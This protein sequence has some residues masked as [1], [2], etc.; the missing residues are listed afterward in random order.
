MFAA[1][2]LCYF[3]CEELLR[4]VALHG[5]CVYN[6]INCGIMSTLLQDTEHLRKAVRLDDIEQ[7]EVAA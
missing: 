4:V 3:N 6:V 7:C 5:K 2:L 1:F